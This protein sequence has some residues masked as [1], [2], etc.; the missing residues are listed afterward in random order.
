MIGDFRLRDD[1]EADDLD[2]WVHQHVIGK[3][4]GL[5]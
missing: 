2:S 1:I 3:S 4:S 5:R